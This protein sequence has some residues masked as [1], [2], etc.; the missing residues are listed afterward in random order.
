MKRN[1][2]FA[3]ILFFA[4]AGAGIARAADPSQNSCSACTSAHLKQLARAA[5]TEEQYS[6]LA[7]CYEKLHSDYLEKAA[8]EKQE[9]ERRSHNVM[10]AAAKYPRPVDSAR[11]LYEYD[12]SKAAEAGELSA[13]FSRQAALH[14]PSKPHQIPSGLNLAM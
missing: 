6:A 8:Q 7:A 1:L 10:A 13:K 4:L 5:S 11:N 9:W 3:S 14:S 12:L 2:L